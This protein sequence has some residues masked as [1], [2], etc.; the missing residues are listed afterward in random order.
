MTDKYNQTYDGEWIDVTDSALIACC[1]C[2]LVHNREHRIIQSED[3]KLR[4]IRRYIIDNR[5]TAARR[6]SLKARREGIF[7]KGKK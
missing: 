3:D 6:R 5:A 1:D 4:I 7:A 2:G